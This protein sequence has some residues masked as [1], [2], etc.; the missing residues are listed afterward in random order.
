MWHGI[1]G[2]LVLA[3]FCGWLWPGAVTAEGVR[4]EGAGAGAVPDAVLRLLQDEPASLLDLCSDA[5][6]GFGGPGGL[7]ADG[8]G[9]A[10][11]VP[12]AEARAIWLHRFW[13]MDLDA[14]GAVSA[15]EAELATSHMSAGTRARALRALDGA[16]LDRDG[17]ASA[18]ELRAGAEAAALRRL[19]EDAAQVLRALPAFDA[20][21]NGLTTREELRRGV[22]ALGLDDGA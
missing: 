4:T 9:A 11:T 6:A 18:V 5:I 14:D 20:D 15:A 13:Q 8:I 21:G 3:L 12:R 16:D 7:D 10:I 19:D 22:A 1:R 2:Y 17:A